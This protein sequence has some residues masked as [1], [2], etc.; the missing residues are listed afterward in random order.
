MAVSAGKALIEQGGSD[1]DV[2]L[3]VTGVFDVVSTGVA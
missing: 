1:N 2:F 3:I